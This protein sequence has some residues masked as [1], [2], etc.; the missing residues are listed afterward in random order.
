MSA[1]DLD[2]TDSDPKTREIEVKLDAPQFP[3]APSGPIRLAAPP[4][5][6]LRMGMTIHV[7]TIRGSLL[8][9]SVLS[10]KT[11]QYE[12]LVLLTESTHQLLVPRED[13]SLRLWKWIRYA[14][15][16]PWLV[17]DLED[18]VGHTDRCRT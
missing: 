7:N 11:L 14:A 6:R 3:A 2:T 8:K 15:H 5:R 9:I 16:Y 10:R 18:A 17:E 13:A 12:L 1:R 4:P